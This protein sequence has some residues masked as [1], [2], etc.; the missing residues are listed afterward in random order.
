MAA[1]NIVNATTII[2]KSTF[3]A[4]SSATG[5]TTILTNTAASGKVLKVNSL[6][7]SNIDGTN[8]YAITAWVY[9]G[10]TLYNIASTVSIPA[11]SSL[12]IIDKSAP[13]YLEEEFSIDLYTSTDN[14][15][16]ATISYEEIT[17]I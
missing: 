1:P 13:I 16:V 11:N 14:K 5:G 9:N 3:Q 2:G 17:D 4:V 7:I 15:L 12:V 8:P 10:A 6:Y